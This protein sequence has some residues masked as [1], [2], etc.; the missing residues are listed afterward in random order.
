MDN[1]YYNVL[2]GLQVDAQAVLAGV[3]WDRTR[4]TFQDMRGHIWPMTSQ[5]VDDNFSLDFV[6]NEGLIAN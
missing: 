5:M 1:T 2:G 4:N 3:I 6:N